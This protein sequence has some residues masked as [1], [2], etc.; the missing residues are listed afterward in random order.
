[1]R[2]DIGDLFNLILPKKEI[3]KDGTSDI[4]VIMMYLIIYQRFGLR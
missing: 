2:L 3:K 1:M 4:L